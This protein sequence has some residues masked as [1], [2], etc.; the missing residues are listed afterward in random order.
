ME[1]IVKIENSAQRLTP[2]T[3]GS[4][5]EAEALRQSILNTKDELVVTGTTYYVS[6]KGDD[7]NDGT[8]P[9]T[10]WQTMDAVINNTPLL[11]AGDAVLFERG[12]IYRRKSTLFVKSG[13]TY[14]AY[15]EGD[16]GVTVVDLK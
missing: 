13:V 16:Y 9:E 1:P 10:A 2:M 5:V 4:D 6:P 14:G 15:G 11:Q 7:A 12:Y 3:G 8:S